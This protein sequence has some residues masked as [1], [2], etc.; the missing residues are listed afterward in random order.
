MVRAKFETLLRQ[1]I[2]LDA[3]SIGSAFIERAVDGRRLA[4]KLADLPSYWNYLQNSPTEFQALIETV[5][6]PETWFFRDRKAFA[7]LA[8]LMLSLPFAADPRRIV[9]VLSLPC[10]SGEEPYS[11]AMAL[12]DAGLPPD[13]LRI[14]AVDIS[15]RVLAEAGRGIYGKNSF[16]GDDLGFRDR[17]FTATSEGMRLNDIVRS[18]VRFQ[19]GNLFA[20]D[21]QP[22][23]ER[24]DAIFCRNLLIY[25]DRAGQ[26]RAVDLLGR[27]LADDGI[28][29][30]GPA[31]AAILLTHGFASTGLPMSFSFR[32]SD[33]ASSVRPPTRAPGAHV[34]TNAARPEQWS[35]PPAPKSRPKRS[36]VRP[37]ASS[38][39][40]PSDELA[41]AGL[42]ADQGRLADA[43]RICKQY[44][45]HDATSARAL[46]LSGVISDASGNMAEAAAYY[47]KVLY[48]DR[49]HTDARFHLALLMEKQGDATAARQMRKRPSR[50]AA[51]A[52]EPA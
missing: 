25:F 14:D 46:Y 2:G 20:P 41:K 9:R 21:F 37:S 5:V 24:Y 35:R 43:A 8:H 51:D 31:E 4:C 10:S 11:V 13:R 15:S 27:L 30:V 18:Q 23:A 39:E 16:R 6:V 34:A 26:D 22:G 52:P 49:D 19:H 50:A 28:L 7:A 3:A 33:P 48:L 17:Y 45:D 44:L 38:A 29:F 40:S 32:K 47:R 42:L 36:I 1:T 12:L